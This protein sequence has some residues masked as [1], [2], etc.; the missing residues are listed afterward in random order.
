MNVSY[1]ITVHATTIEDEHL[2]LSNVVLAL[3]RFPVLPEDVLDKELEGREIPT[4]VGQSDGI[5]QSPADY[6][7][8]LDNDIR[9]SLDYRAVL[10]LEVE[11]NRQQVDKL[12]FTSRFDVGSKENGD[13][14]IV[15]RDS[16]H[17][18]RIWGT[19]HK[20]GE[21]NVGIRDLKV[22]IR[23]K[24][25]DYI[26]DG[27]GRYVFKGLQEG[28]YT[29]VVTDQAGNERA[30]RSINVPLESVSESYDVGI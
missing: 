27:H 5:I 28:T 30:N 22:T 23:E 20:A 7:G 1:N 11:P 25:M 10:K 8:S 13:Q 29:L 15:S 2:L 16:P 14:R 26:T 24:G 6:W 12:V 17:L 18:Y 4:F 3:L 9:P 19:V 21:I